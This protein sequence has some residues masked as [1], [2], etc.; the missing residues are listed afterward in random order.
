MSNI[1]NYPLTATQINDEDFYDVDYWNGV[2]F[3]TRKISGATLKSV[4]SGAEQLNDLIDVNTGL[5]GSP[6]NADDGRVLYFDIDTGTWISDD[7]ARSSRW[8]R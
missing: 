1:H 3:E 5:P 2:A 8:I 7:I 6:T 4:L